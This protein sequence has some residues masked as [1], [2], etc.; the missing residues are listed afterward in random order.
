MIGMRRLPIALAAAAAGLALV[1][2]ALAE[3]IEPRWQR[4]AAELKMPVLRPSVTFGLKLQRLQTQHINCGR[5]KEQ[6]DAYYSRRSDGAKLR[7]AEGKPQYCADLGDAPVVQRGLVHGRKATLYRYCEGPGCRR[8][9][10]AYALVW[11]EQGITIT[12][13]ARGLGRQ[14]LFLIAAS[15]KRVPG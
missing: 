7:I 13:I 4:A 3:T 6:M 10:N 11:S 1:T 2:S 15:M 5:I 9:R 12:Y 14:Q 8:A